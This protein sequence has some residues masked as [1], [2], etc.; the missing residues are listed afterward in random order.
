MKENLKM[1]WGLL[2]ILALFGPYIMGV[3]DDYGYGGVVVA[4]VALV[5]ILI[6]S[7]QVR[8]TFWW[9]GLRRNRKK[10]VPATKEN[11]TTAGRHP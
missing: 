1:F 10:E 4:A 9:R 2:F 6:S 11:S 7:R 8:P 5:L 3:W